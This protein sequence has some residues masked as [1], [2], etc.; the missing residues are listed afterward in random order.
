M[1]CGPA[2]DV[3]VPGLIL[4]MSKSLYVQCEAG[5]N[6]VHDPCLFYGHKTCGRR[7]KKDCV[8]ARRIRRILS[9]RDPSVWTMPKARPQASYLR[10]LE[11][12]V[13]MGLASA[14]TMVRHWPI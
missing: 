4:M 14:W 10:Q 13:M 11:D 5:S 9:C 7:Y 12:I 1:I 2:V 8:L 3:W 6:I